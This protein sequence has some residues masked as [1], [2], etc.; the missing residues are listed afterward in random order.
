[1]RKINLQNYMI[2]ARDENGQVVEVPYSVKESL[3]G[4]LF[5]P[6]LEIDG[7]ELILRSKLADK[8]D[9]A[10]DEILLE[11]VDYSKCKLAVETITG[12]TK[13]DIEFVERI[14]EA[15]AIEVKEK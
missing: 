5:H 4:I 10:E 2:E 6:T 11:E 14:L 1:M 13:N 15:E 3:T 7:R 12:Y 8:I 9:A